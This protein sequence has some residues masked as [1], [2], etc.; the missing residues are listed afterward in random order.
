MVT[1]DHQFARF[2]HLRVELRQAAE[3][4][5]LAIVRG[6]SAFIV[7]LFTEMYGF[8]LTISRLLSAIAGQAARIVL[9]AIGSAVG[10]VPTGNTGATSVSMFSGARTAPRHV[11]NTPWPQGI[12]K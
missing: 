8:P 2:H 3:R 5:R 9:G 10:R 12:A 6:F 11:L 4:P 1:R 7:A